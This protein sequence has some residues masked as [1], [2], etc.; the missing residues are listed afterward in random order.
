VEHALTAVSEFSEGKIKQALQD[1]CAAF[2]ALAHYLEQDVR[3][4]HSGFFFQ[5]NM[6]RYLTDI[7]LCAAAMLYEWDM[8]R[9]P[10]S[11]VKEGLTKD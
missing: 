9:P 7:I 5:D 6:P 10:Y 4:L 1:K 2:Y 11:P 3:C 8:S